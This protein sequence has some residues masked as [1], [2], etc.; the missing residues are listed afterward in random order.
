MR[1]ISFVILAA[2]GV[3]FL[4][5]PLLANEKEGIDMKSEKAILAGGCFW[6]TE[7]VFKGVPGVIDAVS[8]Y[9]GGAVENPSYEQVSMGRTGHFEAVEVTFDPSKI[10]Y[11]AVLDVF[12]RDIDPTDPGGQFND[13]GDQYRT[14]IFYLN[15]EQKKTAEASKSKL[16]ASGKFDKPIATQILKAEKFY[17]AEDYHQDYSEKAPAHYKM[18]R[19]GSGREDF[20]KNTW[21]KET[22]KPAKENNAS[23]GESYKKPPAGELKK[24]LTPLQF[25]VTQEEGTEPPFQNEYWNNHREGI[26]VDVVSG[27]PLFSSTDKYESGTGWPSFMRPLEPA[28]LVEKEDGK[29]LMKRIEVRSKHG[30]SHLGHV[31]DDGPEPTGLRYCMNSAS[32]RFIPKEDLEKEGYGEYKQLFK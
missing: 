8:G 10:S 6:C 12:W 1:K 20:V 23:G 19:K 2:A 26:Y 27:E 32:L 24:K 31:F 11:E 18:Y 9:T 25:K 15:D 7:S 17:P 30:D 28:N 3:I 4:S 22:S 21:G 29:L 16:A 13:R 14:A 5:A